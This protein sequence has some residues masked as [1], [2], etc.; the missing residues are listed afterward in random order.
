MVAT[1]LLARGSLSVVATTL[2]WLGGFG[3]W[4]LFEYAVHGWVQHSPR[5]RPWIRRWNDHA[6]HHPNP[7]DPEGF[8]S[9]LG[10]TL[11]LAVVICGL[12]YAAAPT[13]AA[14]LAWQAGF[15]AGY[16]VHEWIH[17]ASH[18][19]ELHRGAPGS[20][21]GPRGTFGTTG[22]RRTRPTAS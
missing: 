6:I 12:T 11:P 19:P 16:L 20:R 9:T 4:T 7:D 15:C 18:L 14:A 2:W 8:V 3:F 13:F 21:A 10:E 5:I 17:C 22:N 1:V